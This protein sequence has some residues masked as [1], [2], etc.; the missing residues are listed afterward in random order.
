MP[1]PNSQC[2]VHGCGVWSNRWGEKS[3]PLPSVEIFTL[4][5]AST[6]DTSIN[7]RIC[8]PCWKRHKDYTMKLDGR[9]RVHLVASPSPLDALLS[10]AIS[11]LPPSPSPPPSH[12]CVASLPSPRTPARIITPSPAYPIVASYP[13]QVHGTAL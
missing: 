11:P 13:L 3:Y 2:P 7:N 12:P 5:L 6:V 10:A 9:V 8:Q 4:Q 1:T